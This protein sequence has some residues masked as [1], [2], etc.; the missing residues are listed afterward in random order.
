MTPDRLKRLND[1]GFVWDPIADEWEVGFAK[2]EQFKARE[3]HCRVPANYIEGDFK[4]GLWVAAQRK[5]RKL[6]HAERGTSSST[7]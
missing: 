6:M 4:L 3:G 2:L 7:M 5:N 1:I